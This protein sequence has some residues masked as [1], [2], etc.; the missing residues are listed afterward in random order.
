M[1][2]LPV[3]DCVWAA[4]ATPHC[5]CSPLMLLPYQRWRCLQLW[6]SRDRLGSTKR[7][8]RGLPLTGWQPAGHQAYLPIT[9][10]LS[11]GPVNLPDRSLQVPLILLIQFISLT[12][13]TRLRSA[14]EI[15]PSPRSR[16]PRLCCPRDGKPNPLSGRWR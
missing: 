1:T 14:G 2:V 9:S 10:S 8:G 15:K 12:A 11:G 5:Q 3:S 4:P 16:P 6:G 13:R 7:E